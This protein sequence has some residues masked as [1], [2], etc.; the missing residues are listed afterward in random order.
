[1]TRDIDPDRFGPD[2]TDDEAIDYVG[3][4]DRYFYFNAS[5]ELTRCSS[6]LITNLV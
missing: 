4:E 1:L 5:N 3:F 2:D 6:S